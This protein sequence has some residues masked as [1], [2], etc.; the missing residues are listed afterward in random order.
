MNRATLYVRASNLY[1]AKAQLQEEALAMSLSPPPVKCLGIFPTTM[2]AAF[3]HTRVLAIYLDQVLSDSQYHGRP[4]CRQCVRHC[5]CCLLV[6][7]V[8]TSN[9]GQLSKAQCYWT[10]TVDDGTGFISVMSQ[11]CLEC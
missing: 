10:S 4:R 3:Q 6:D 2:E 9:R 5:R 1:R 8:D 11:D 7:S